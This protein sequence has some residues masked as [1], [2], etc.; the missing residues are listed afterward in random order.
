MLH[1]HTYWLVPL[2]LYAQLLFFYLYLLGSF[3]LSIKLTLAASPSHGP[4]LKL[5]LD[6]PLCF[7]ASRI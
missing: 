6:I 7:S 3:P 5:F 1:L 2:P 4:I